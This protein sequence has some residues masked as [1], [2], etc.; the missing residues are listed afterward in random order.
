M[1]YKSRRKIKRS[2]GKSK[3]SRKLRFRSKKLKGGN[4]KFKQVFYKDLDL[5][6]ETVY[7]DQDYVKIGIY[8]SD[9]D[10]QAVTFK[11][12]ADNTITKNM[13]LDKIYKMI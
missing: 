3:K 8:Q 11:D 13:R 10:P 4:N 7:Y 1:G 6:G 9:G 5:K 12:E 2:R